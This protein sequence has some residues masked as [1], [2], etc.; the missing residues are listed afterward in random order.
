MKLEFNRW[1]QAEEEILR[2]AYKAGGPK[3]AMER[4]PARSLKAI[5][6]RANRLGLRSE[7]DPVAVAKEVSQKR[8]FELAKKRLSRLGDDMH[9]AQELAPRW[10]IT[11][12]SVGKIAN[13]YIAE[14][15]LAR[16]SG[17][18]YRRTM[19]A[20][21]KD[22]TVTA[23]WR[24]ADRK[25]KKEDDGTFVYAMPPFPLGEVKG[26]LGW[27][28]HADLREWHPEAR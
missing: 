3:L 8:A 16:L 23:S 2:E 28:G 10:G 9:T 21:E 14:G 6:G 12:A 1:T 26:M 11:A 17:N 5:K 15:Y 19:K 13:R 18:R 7:V 4:L 24:K 20:F 27:A 25:R 22:W